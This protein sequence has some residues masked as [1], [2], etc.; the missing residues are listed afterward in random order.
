MAQSSTS[1]HPISKSSMIFSSCGGSA[2]YWSILLMLMGHSLYFPGAMSHSKGKSGKQQ[3]V[4]GSSQG[5][6][7]MKFSLRDSDFGGANGRSWAGRGV[8]SVFRPSAKRAGGTVEGRNASSPQA[9]VH[10]GLP[11][12]GARDP[13]VHVER[14]VG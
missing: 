1:V 4:T 5:G 2:A 10:A 8:E 14:D 3:M 13:G 7:G 12:E 6:L 9:S 11:P